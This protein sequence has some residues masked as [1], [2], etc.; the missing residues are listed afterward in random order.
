MASSNHSNVCPKESFFSHFPLPSVVLLQYEPDATI[1]SKQEMQD[2]TDIDQRTIP[3]VGV[4]Q[5]RLF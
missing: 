5:R 2:G 4:A 3:S 1:G